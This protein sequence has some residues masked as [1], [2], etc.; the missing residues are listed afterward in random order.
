[1]CGSSWENFSFLFFSRWFRCCFLLDI[2]LLLGI[3]CSE[4]LRFFFGYLYFPCSVLAEKKAKRKEAY[5]DFLFHNR[6]LINYDVL[7]TSLISIH[8]SIGRTWDFFFVGRKFQQGTQS[9]RPWNLHFVLFCAIFL[10]IFFLSNF[11]RNGKC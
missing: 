4:F 1:M 6:S 9:F 3:I 11:I 7:F 5:M 2:F 10:K 8:F